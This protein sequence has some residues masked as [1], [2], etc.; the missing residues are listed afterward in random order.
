I[1]I[2]DGAQ[3]IPHM[4]VNVEKL[5]VD[6]LVF[7]GH[8]MLASMGVGVL[9]GKL[10]RLK[11]M[12]PFL[13]GGGMVEYVDLYDTAYDE[14]SYKFEAGTKN[15][16]GVVALSAAIVDIDDMGMDA[17]ET[18]EE[19]LVKYT[20]EK[21]EENKYIKIHGGINLGERK[22]IVSFNV[23]DVHPHDVATILDSKN[24]AIRAGHHCAQPFMKYMG[25]NSTSRAS[26]YF[27][28]TFEDIDRLAKALEEVRG[29]L[30]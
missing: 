27:Y 1:T 4:K 26:F 7:S 5:G 22:S 28:N 16:E 13:F 6:F 19:E 21:L 23:K 14:T 10:E 12:E 18:V 3:S 9:Y 25:L 29:Y 11:K 30:L 24:I 8:K 2:I 15:V 17:I 20:L